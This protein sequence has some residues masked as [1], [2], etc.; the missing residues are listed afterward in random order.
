VA[1]ALGGFRPALVARL[2]RLGARAVRFD[3]AM[4]VT[5]VGAVPFRS[6]TRR[7]GAMSR[8]QAASLARYFDISPLHRAA[9][10]AMS[11]FSG[12]RALLR[13]VRSAITEGSA[14]TNF[15]L[16]LPL[17]TV[18]LATRWI[19][20]DLGLARPGSEGDSTLRTAEELAT[21]QREASAR[22]P[23]LKS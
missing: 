19:G 3:P 15:W 9:M 5:A 23:P 12:L 14:D 20:R 6:S 11:P 4:S 21:V 16:S 7:I 17:S 22:M 1:R 10:I 8:F 13:I 18:A 2:N